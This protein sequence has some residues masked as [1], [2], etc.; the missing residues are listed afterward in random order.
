MSQVSSYTQANGSG[1][2]VRTGFNAI[3]AALLTKAGGSVTPTEISQFMD[4]IDTSGANPIWKVRNEANSAFIDLA[5]FVGGNIRLFSD[6]GAIPSVASANTFT[7]DQ[8]VKLAAAV[9]QMIVG[10]ALSSGIPTR[11]PMIG[12][13]STAAQ[14]IYA[15]IEADIETNTDG[16]EDG[17][18]LL[19]LIRGGIVSEIM[20]LGAGV[21]IGSPAGGLPGNG[22]LNAEGLEIGGTDILATITAASNSAWSTVTL[23]S[24]ANNLNLASF[25]NYDITLDSADVTLN[26]QNPTTQIGRM[27]LIRLNNTSGGDRTVTLSNANSVEIGGGFTTDGTTVVNAASEKYLLFMVKSTTLAYVFEFVGETAQTGNGFSSFVQFDLTSAQSGDA[28]Q[29]LQA[30]SDGETQRVVVHNV[31]PTNNVDDDLFVRVATS[32]TLLIPGSGTYDSRGD[33]F[34][35]SQPFE[36]IAIA[37]CNDINVRIHGEF[38][39]RREGTQLWCNSGLTSNRLASAGVSSHKSGGSFW[40]DTFTHWTLDFETTNNPATG[41]QWTVYRDIS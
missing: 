41:S 7:A 30:I 23:S 22:I 8:T 36:G 9:G 31:F 33:T 34:Q 12:H 19:S 2:V 26:F 11:I 1:N 14:R 13:S 39:V 32:G 37:D 25:R 3:I 18:M 21:Q 38:T 28:L 16:N 20:R 27:G 24:G 15:Q 29:R 35:G 4:F 40:G 6:G 10:S 5:E 17:R